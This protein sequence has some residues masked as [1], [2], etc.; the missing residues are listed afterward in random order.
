MGNEFRMFG[1][2][3]TGKTTRLATR[4]IPRACEKFGNDKI[5]VTSFTKAGAKEIAHKPSMETGQTIMV[6]PENVGTLHSIIYNA[7]GSPGIAE[8]H[9]KEWNESYPSMAIG[10][11]S[12]DVLDEGGTLDG[13]SK[14]ARGEMLLNALNIHRNR[15]TWNPSTANPS[16]KHFK[17]LWDEWKKAN[18]LMDFTD[19]I[20]YA[21]TDMPYAP[22][23]P[24]VL[25]V[26]EAQ[27]FT[28][29][30]LSVIRRWGLSTQWIVLVGDDDQ[31]I[32]GFTGAQHNAFLQP[33]VEPKF[34]TV[35]KHSFRVPAAVLRRSQQLIRQVSEREPKTYYPRTDIKG[36]PV[37]GEVIDTYL[38]Y[39]MADD[40]LNEAQQY[41]QM[42][43]RVMFLGSC[44]YH[45]DP[46]KKVLRNNGLP[47]WNPYRRRRG[48]WNPLA[49]AGRGKVSAKDLIISFMEMGADE[50]YW[51]IPGFV[52]WAQFLAVGDGTSGLLKVKGNKAIKLLKE[53]IEENEEGLHSCRAVIDKVLAPNAIQRA[54]DR[55]L[56]WLIK[57]LKTQKAESLYYPLK[58]LTNHG[59]DALIEEPKITIGTIH[60]VKGG[61]SDV[62]FLFPDVSYQADV[63][64]QSRSGM[65]AAC[66]L[67]YVGMT[68]ARES[69]ILCDPV[70]GRSVNRQ[71]MYMDL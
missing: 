68:R 64:M 28:K 27:D 29:L 38:N 47:F 42:G 39:R 35:L 30:Q 19:L 43:K 67:F 8:V 61:E 59:Q 20:E 32:Y 52:R 24:E 17:K 36:E 31:T 10:G 58:V 53:A 40:L 48:D 5:M 34:K 16:V 7:L 25:F 56:K 22:N 4:D 63:E 60:S 18:N 33:P 62:V 13:T 55:D 15:M 46:I 23:N 3:G 2:P 21:H 45:I 57:N 71:R 66:R 65:D 41:L 6:N 14:A 69:L 9:A 12:A 49:S 70:V 11:V 37:E 54:L 50:P 44:S 26:D 1:P 51:S